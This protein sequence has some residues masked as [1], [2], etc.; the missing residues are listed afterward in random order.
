MF[1]I[2]PDYVF[3]DD[4]PLLSLEELRDYVTRE[5][6]LP[7][8]PSSKD[9]KKDGLS[10]GEF[11]MTLLEKVEELTL[12]TLA[13]QEEIDQ[14]RSQLGQPPA[15][16]LRWIGVVEVIG[17]HHGFPRLKEQFGDSG[18]DK[19]GTSGDQDCHGRP[20]PE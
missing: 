20:I 4:Y 6:H 19:A 3:E 16:Q 2:V 17:P 7:N 5:R 8:V 14:L 15:L 18:A 1:L 12:Y 11:Q 9:I 13:Q 10:L